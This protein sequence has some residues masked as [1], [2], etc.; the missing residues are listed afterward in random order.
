MAAPSKVNHSKFPKP[1]ILYKSREF[2]VGWGTYDKRRQ[3]LG[4]RWN[5]APTEPGYPKLFKNPVWFV[6]PDSLSGPFLKALLDIDRAKTDRVLKT[7]QELL[8]TA[9]TQARPRHKPK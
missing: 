6:L 7:L 2:A 5:G 1:R 9:G 4:M 8:R 3:C